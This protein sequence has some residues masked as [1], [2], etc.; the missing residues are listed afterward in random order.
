MS[1]PVGR[2]V[3]RVPVHPVAIHVLWDVQADEGVVVG[4]RRVRVLP[5]LVEPREVVEASAVGREPPVLPAGT[6]KAGRRVGPGQEGCIDRGV[7]RVPVVTSPWVE[8]SSDRLSFDQ[9]VERTLIESVKN[10][11]GFLLMRL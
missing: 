11:A 5:V 3:L 1:I 10:A 9:A 8:A 6:F 7:G 2:V 4:E